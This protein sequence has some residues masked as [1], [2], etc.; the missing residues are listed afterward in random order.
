M[1]G[2]NDRNYLLQFKH[3]FNY[4]MV[5]FIFLQKKWDSYSGE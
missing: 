3:C 2:M 1:S 5:L 4:Y